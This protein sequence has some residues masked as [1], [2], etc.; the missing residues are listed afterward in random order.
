MKIFFDG[1]GSLDGMKCHEIA[2]Y[3][4]MK[5]RGT[6]EL[7]SNSYTQGVREEMHWIP[8]KDIDKYRAYP[9]F[10]KRNRKFTA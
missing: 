8:I 5:P 10:L 1:D 4:I 7:N 3:Y 6:Q 2:L 9:S